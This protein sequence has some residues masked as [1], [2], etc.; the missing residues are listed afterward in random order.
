MRKSIIVIRFI[1]ALAFLMT[2]S[3]AVFATTLNVPQKVQERSNWCWAGC[4][5]AILE[6]YGTIVTQTDIAAYGTPGSDNEW[7]WLY[8]ESSNP[9]RRG[10]D[11]ILNHFASIGSTPYERCL[12]QS[13]VGTEINAGRPPVIRWGWDSGGG[14]FVVGRGIDGD[15]MY[16]MDPW[17]GPTVNTYSWVVR[18][19]TH[20]WTH[21]L[22]LTSNPPSRT[23]T[24]T[25]TITSTPTRTPAPTDTPTDTPT[26]TA[27]PIPPEI[28][29]IMRNENTGD[30]TISW[31]GSCNV[32]VYYAV[33]MQSAFNIA[34]S[35][36]SGG[37]WTDD[38]T[39]TAGHPNGASERYYKV[40]CSGISQYASDAVGMFRYDL[41][42]GYNLICLP[43]ISYDRDID[44]VFGTQ[45]TEGGAL[46]GDRIYTQDPDYGSLMK[47]AYLSSSSHKWKG[48][49]DEALIAPEKGYF[50]QIRT[51]H[52]RLTQY[53]VGKVA[54]GD[55]E[56]PEFVRGYNM[57]GSV[58]PVDVNF[59]LSNLKESGAN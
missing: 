4:S 18:G 35:D 40:A 15:T 58:W 5:Q 53:V 56:M 47:Y 29:N 48:V 31:T 54:S 21:S 8:G 36:V 20:T 25:P 45:L 33:D 3:A 28:A 52:T 38:G 27:T 17:Y 50:L 11:L 44:M 34:Q 22:P 41:A 19:G 57:I 16:L 14:H 7:N 23:P 9:T 32:D 37:S 6:Y 51:G 30:I 24:E 49:L 12:T 46:T 55:V 39:S 1:F 13:E 42:V 59:N 43:V 2:G 10:I 26:P